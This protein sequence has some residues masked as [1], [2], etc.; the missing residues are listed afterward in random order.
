VGNYAAQKYSKN[1]GVTSVAQV[2]PPAFH[3][4]FEFVDEQG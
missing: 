3:P 2:L 4:D 1:E